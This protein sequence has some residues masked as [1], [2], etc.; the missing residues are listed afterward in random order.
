M[1]WDISLGVFVVLNAICV[2]A[3]ANSWPL[4]LV[5]GLFCLYVL[6]NKG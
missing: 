1:L 2:V 5:A 6:I 3:Q 4:N